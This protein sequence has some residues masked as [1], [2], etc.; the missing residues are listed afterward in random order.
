MD[1]QRLTHMAQ[2]TR[3]LGPDALLLKDKGSA[4]ACFAFDA[5]DRLIEETDHIGT[6]LQLSNERGQVIWRGAN[7]DW[8]A[9]IAA[10]GSIEQPIRFQGQ[11]HDQESGLYYNRH[12]YYLPK[13]GRYASQDP[14]GFRGG[15]NGCVYAL[16]IPSVAYDPSGLFVPLLL[17]GFLK[18]AAITQAIKNKHTVTDW[19]YW[20]L[21]AP[22]AGD[23]PV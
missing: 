2:I 3:P 22:S 6:P 10:P 20:V 8:R 23:S 19:L 7:D 14:I 9:V 17:I 1:F 12:R 18:A 21:N 15:P 13:A 4:K 11:Y 16:N 5:V